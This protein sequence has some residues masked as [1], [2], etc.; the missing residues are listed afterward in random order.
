[1]DIRGN[2]TERKNMCIMS[3]CSD[4]TVTLRRNMNLD[5]NRGSRLHSLNTSG[6][7]NICFNHVYC[8]WGWSI[9]LSSFIFQCSTKERRAHHGTSSR[10][11]PSMWLSTAR[12][13]FVCVC[14]NAF[15]HLHAYVSLF[16]TWALLQFSASFDDI[17]SICNGLKCV[18]D[19]VCME[20]TSSLRGRETPTVEFGK[21]CTAHHDSSLWLNGLR[22]CT[23]SI[24]N[25][26]PHTDLQPLHRQMYC[27]CSC[28]WIHIDHTCTHK[29]ST[30]DSSQSCVLLSDFSSGLKMT[31]KPRLC[32]RVF[33]CIHVRLRVW[34]VRST[35]ATTLGS[36][37]WLRIHLVPPPSSW[38]RTTVTSF[39]WT[40]K[41]STG[42]SG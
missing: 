39:V 31:S 37:P 22:D 6:V 42:Y 21:L 4:V 25:F 41:T 35:R 30:D 11:A 38:E 19:H 13:L 20:Q 1:M 2:H 23:H 33:V 26:T 10:R 40:R 7:Q 18:A 24:H 36:W 27:T 15:I 14:L 17:S 29:T 34:C 5:A 16:D 8:I 32:L 12:W 3:V 28:A 9:C